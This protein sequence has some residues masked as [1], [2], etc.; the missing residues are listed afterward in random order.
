[1]Q[2]ATVLSTARTP[3]PLFAMVQSRTL[4]PPP[5]MIPLV[6]FPATLQSLIRQPTLA[7]VV[8]VLMPTPFKLAAQCSTEHPSE[9]EMPAIVLS[10]TVHPIAEHFSSSRIPMPLLLRAL[11]WITVLPSSA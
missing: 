9:V 3:V 7:N 2:P 1:M 11:Q 5:A 8:G 4:V 10:C 6:L